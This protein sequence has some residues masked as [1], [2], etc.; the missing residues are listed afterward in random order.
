MTE[1]NR[2]ATASGLLGLVDGS[3]PATTRR[4][5]VVLDENAVVQL[6]DLVTSRQTLANGIELVHYGIV[7]EGSGEIEGAELPSDTYRISGAGTMPGLTSRRIEVQTLRTI[8]ELW[9]PP[10]PGAVV[11]RAVGSARD[12]A[13]FLDQMELPLTV[14]HDQDHQP[15]VADF[16]FVNGEKGGHVSISGVSGVATKTSYALFLLYMLF[17]TEEG[18]RLLGHNAANTRSIVFNVK[19]EDLLHLDRP[20][21]KLGQIDGALDGWKALGVDSPGPFKRVRLFAPRAAR[22]KPG[23][24]S[25]DVVSRDSK[26]LVVYGWAPAD[27]IREELLR[28]CFAGGRLGSGCDAD[29]VTR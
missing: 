14:G 27:F 28:F 15:I 16:A 24:L 7:V 4:F 2:N 22:S 29:G 21:A 3:A 6:D 10:E 13:L 17:E 26:D 5:H 20:N 9:M 8:P 25:T 19:G 11:E 18:R 1:E 23:S 12:D